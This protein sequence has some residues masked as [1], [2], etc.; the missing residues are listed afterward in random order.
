MDYLDRRDVSYNA[1]EHQRTRYP[2]QIVFKSGD[3]DIQAGPMANR[4]YSKQTLQVL[5]GVRT[6]RE[7]GNTAIPKDQGSRQNDQLDQVI[8][9]NWSGYVEHGKKLFLNIHQAPRRHGHR[10]GGVVKSGKQD[11]GKSTIWCKADEQ[12]SLSKLDTFANLAHFFNDIP[13]EK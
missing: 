2:H 6:E 12:C 7:R 4:E 13:A 3:P 1:A 10:V 8:Q 5:L 11:A 9:E